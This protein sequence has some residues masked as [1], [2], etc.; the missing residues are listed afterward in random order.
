MIPKG[1]AMISLIL[2]VALST[3]AA[4][5][6]VVVPGPICAPEDGN[7][8]FPSD[9]M[10]IGEEAYFKPECEP[11]SAPGDLL[12][13]FNSHVLKPTAA[14]IIESWRAVIAADSRSWYIDGHTDAIGSDAYNF[15]LSNRR[16]ESVRDALVALGVPATRLVA[17]GFGES[18]PVTSNRTQAGRDRNRRVEVLPVA[19]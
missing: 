8:A 15:R 16:A 6:V 2:V 5:P 1:Y 14:P 11:L 12:F 4:E 10:T 13:A 3:A 7:L 17:R 19:E 18:K 9:G